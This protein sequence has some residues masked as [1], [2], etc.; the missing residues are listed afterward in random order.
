VD[1]DYCLGQGLVLL[2]VQL[3]GLE[4]GRRAGRKLAETVMMTV[5]ERCLVEPHCFAVLKVA[6]RWLAGRRHFAASMVEVLM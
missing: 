2:G 1:V 5:G 4:E 3:I 6:E